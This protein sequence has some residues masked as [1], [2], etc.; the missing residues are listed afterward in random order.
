MRFTGGSQSRESSQPEQ[1]S[2]L[3]SMTAAENRPRLLRSH[4]PI[5]VGG[6]N[7]LLSFRNGF[8]AIGSRSTTALK[9]VLASR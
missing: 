3:R 6:E 1:D 5:P 4:V 7:E 2:P 9:I 8:R